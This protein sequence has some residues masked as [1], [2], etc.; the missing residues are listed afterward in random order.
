MIKNG[1]FYG[2]NLLLI[3]LIYSS[4]VLILKIYVQN[5]DLGFYHIASSII[6]VICLIPQSI[7][8]YFFTENTDYDALEKNKLKSDVIKF[9]IKICICIALF[10]M[11]LSYV[12]INF[13]CLENYFKSLI[14]IIILSPGLL[15]L[16]LIKIIY[17][18]LVRKISPVNFLKY[19]CW[20]IVKCI[21]KY[22]FDSF[23]F[24]IWRSIFFIIYLFLYWLII[25]F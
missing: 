1:F 20:C 3:G 22:F 18:S 21:V 14:I 24:N 12:M 10:T 15:G 6:N 17:T 23:I 4:D 11:F 2:I 9:S 16:F 13:L 19:Y 25:V 8:L 7:G 5:S